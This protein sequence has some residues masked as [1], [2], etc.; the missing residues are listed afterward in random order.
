ML[1]LLHSERF[2]NLAPAEVWAT[3]LDEGRY[4]CSESTMYRLLRQVRGQV[5]ERRRQAV[6][7]P[8]V[9]PELVAD[10][11]NRCWSWG[12][13]KL[14]GPAKW[15]YYYLYSIIDIYSRDTVGPSALTSTRRI[16]RLLF[17]YGVPSC[18]VTLGPSQ[19]QVSL[20]GQALPF[21]QPPAPPTVARKRQAS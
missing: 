4:L 13:T 20:T 12:I 18:S 8:Q 1:D 6:D 16:R 9:K 17:T 15:T 14:A 19:A 11:S 2:V 7:P 5:H 21:L 10:G 3:L